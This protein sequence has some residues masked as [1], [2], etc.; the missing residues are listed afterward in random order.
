MVLQ[1]NQINRIWGAAE[2]GE[3]ISVSI[4]RQNHT[5]RAN[6]DGNWQVEI[7][8][9]PSSKVGYTLTIE[10]QNRIE[11][12][13]VLV[14]EVWLCS[15]QS[16]MEWP[17]SA[18]YDSDIEKIISWNPYIRLISVPKLGTQEA[19]T[20]FEG[21]WNKATPK[22][23]MDFSAVG[24][25]FGRILHQSL[26][27]P[28]GLIDN[29]WGGSAAEAWMSRNVLEGIGAAEPYLEKW[30]GIEQNYDHDEV[31]SE[32]NIKLHEW[33]KISKLARGKNQNSSG[34]PRKPRNPLVGQHR[35]SNLYNGVL[36]PIIG[37]GIRGVIWYQGE[38]NTRRAK[39]Y[40]DLFPS[41]IESW[42]HEWGQGP[43]PFYWVQLDDF[44]EENARPENHGW[45][46]LREAQTMT[47]DRLDNTG[48]AVTI[49]IGEGRD[50]HPRNKLTVAKRL[51]RWALANDYGF[52]IDYQSP[53][54]QRMEVQRNKLLLTF[55]HVGQGLYSFD[56]REPRGFSICGED[57][58]FVWAQAKIVDKSQVLVWAKS[59]LSPTHVRYAWAAN[60]V[61]NIM[62]RSGLP[63]TPFR[64]DDFP[65]LTLGR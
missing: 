42:R 18:T 38:S 28:V 33:E 46:E 64:T 30:S 20:D 4:A 45:A 53:R 36:K 56:T 14:G 15:G 11:I 31:L 51:A 7:N 1:R 26:D 25:F 47:L 63:L 13:D 27:V 6:K 54:F 24:F 16:N 57:G 19:Q 55:N 9:M 2:V 43:F 49:N 44:Q 58:V 39:A 22:F 32:F 62:S 21:E 52:S 23:V 12:E 41:L 59:V 61:C 10:G 5:T 3:K 29:S 50:I 17:V 48:Q 37:Y 34:R 35:P 60:P 65:M 40:R 8:P